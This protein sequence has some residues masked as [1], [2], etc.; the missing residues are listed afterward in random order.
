MRAYT[1]DEA[2]HL[3]LTHLAGLIEHFSTKNLSV[4]D[5]L[6]AYTQSILSTFD[7][8]NVAMPAYSIAVNPHPEDKEFHQKNLDNWYETTIFNNEARMRRE[9]E[10]IYYKRKQNT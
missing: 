9:F 10:E 5:A 2:R 7:G 6:L 4:E 1:N 3:F 8:M